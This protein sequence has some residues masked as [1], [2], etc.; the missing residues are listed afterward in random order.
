MR[1][2][3][4]KGVE[5]LRRLV[6]HIVENLR[7]DYACRGLT[8]FLRLFAA[9]R[10]RGFF[11]LLRERTDE[12][13]VTGHWLCFRCILRCCCS[14]TL[15]IRMPWLGGLLR[16]VGCVR[17][18]RLRFPLAI[19][20][21]LSLAERTHSREDGPRSNRRTFNQAHDVAFCRR[22]QRSPAGFKER[23]QACD[24]VFCGVW[25]FVENWAKVR[26]FNQN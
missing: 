25:R 9:C 19:F 7:A 23:I 17:M 10:F 4:Y 3:F 8:N 22:E 14:R 5:M 1:M 26:M 6:A 15:C 18:G 24:T 16:Y 11:L 21:V 13:R 20:R 12:R 2:A